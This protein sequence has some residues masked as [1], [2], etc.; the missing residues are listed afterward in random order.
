MSLGNWMGN[1]V[2]IVWEIGNT[3]EELPDKR[4]DKTKGYPMVNRYELFVR[5]R[6]HPKLTEKIVKSVKYELHPTYKTP[7]HTVNEYPFSHKN[8]AWGVFYIPITI[9]FKEWTK[10]KPI[11]HSYYLWFGGA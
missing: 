4:K 11:E 1:N 7:I 3:W 6:D 9:T 10:L 5:V 2:Q 8:I